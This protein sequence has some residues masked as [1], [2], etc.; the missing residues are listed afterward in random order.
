MLQEISLE[1]S[2]EWDKVVKSFH[3]YDLYYLSG[4]VMAFA[5]HGDGKP[6]L[7][8]YEDNKMRGINVVMLRDIGMADVLREKIP[9]K[10]YYDLITP[11]GYGGFLLEGEVITESITNLSV[12]YQRY[13]M[14]KGIVSE[15]VRFHPLLRNEKNMYSL[16]D[17]KELGRTVSIE[18]ESEEC[19]WNNLTSK[20]RN[21]VRKAKREGV[22][23]YRGQENKL[24]KIFLPMYYETMIK[25]GASSYYFFKSSFF[26]CIQDNLNSNAIVFYA[27][28]EGTVIAMS[29]ILFANQYMHYHLSAS[30]KTYSKLASTNLLLYEAACWGYQKG[31]REFH[32]GGGLGNQEDSLYKFKHSFNRSSNHIFSIGTKIYDI[33]KYNYLIKICGNQKKD[34]NYFP[35][36]RAK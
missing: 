20:N 9:L 28:Y 34:V 3:S 4:Y 26:K 10:T 2:E 17:I 23:I 35:I 16:Y 7:V 27:V 8:Y 29:I 25:D 11:Y 22:K 30:N 5:E 18:L 21:M 19:I 31:F 32:L 36:Y 1:N 6:L 33:E 24:Y 14:D 15:F 13:C 12:E